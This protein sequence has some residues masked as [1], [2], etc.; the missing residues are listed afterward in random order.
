MVVLSRGALRVAR[1]LPIF[2]VFSALCV[3][4]TLLK[5]GVSNVQAQSASLAL[6]ERAARL[7]PPAVYGSAA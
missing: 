2:A 6:P 1:S 7:T 4:V 5:S 3:A